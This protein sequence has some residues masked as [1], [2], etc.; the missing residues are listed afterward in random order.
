[1][2]IEKYY[3]HHNRQHWAISSQSLGWEPNDLPQIGWWQSI[4]FPAYRF[5]RLRDAPN[6]LLE[7]VEVEVNGY[8]LRW[9]ELDEDITVPGVV[10][11]RFELPPEPDE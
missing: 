1:M 6:E 8:A 9:E 2:L 3:E 11:G 10:A 5:S 4:C 7:K